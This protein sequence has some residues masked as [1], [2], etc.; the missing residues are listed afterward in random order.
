MLVI[1]GEQLNDSSHIMELL[2]QKLAVPTKSWT[3]RAASS[4]SPFATPEEEKWFRCDCPGFP[5]DAVGCNTLAGA[6]ALA[7]WPPPETPAAPRCAGGLM[8]DL[9]TC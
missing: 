9:C 1:D 6:A 4:S 7:G 8:I 3:G 5:A 2:A